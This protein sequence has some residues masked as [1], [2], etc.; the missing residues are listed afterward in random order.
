[1]NCHENA[2]QTRGTDPANGGFMA[3]VVRAAKGGL[4]ISTRTLIVVLG[5]DVGTPPILPA[6]EP[7][8]TLEEA[9]SDQLIALSRRMTESSGLSVVLV[10]HNPRIAGKADHV[11]R[12]NSGQAESD[13][14]AA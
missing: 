11:V 9:T 10:T 7:T 14:R 1:M 3:T 2:K 6:D 12:F 4:R 13:R 8:G 5:L